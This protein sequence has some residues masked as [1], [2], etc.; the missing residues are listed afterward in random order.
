MLLRFIQTTRNFETSTNVCALLSCFFF[1]LIFYGLKFAGGP[2]T[3]SQFFC[4]CS[5]VRSRQCFCRNNA[6][7]K[8]ATTTCMWLKLGFCYALSY[9]GTIRV[10]IFECAPQNVVYIILHTLCAIMCLFCLLPWGAHLP[11]SL[12]ASAF[13]HAFALHIICIYTDL[14]KSV[15]S[16]CLCV[17]VWIV[18]EHL[19]LCF[20]LA[21]CEIEIFEVFHCENGCRCKCSVVLPSATFL[22]R[23]RGGILHTAMSI[24]V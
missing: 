11:R 24:A 8:R 13:R 7:N 17:C 1:Q 5:F 2:W 4:S 21:N 15:V 9:T 23:L 18:C 3:H 14:P 12:F 22:M 6:K 10:C 19:W 20:R 16:V